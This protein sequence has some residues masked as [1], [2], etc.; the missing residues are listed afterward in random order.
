MTRLEQLKSLHADMQMTIDAIAAGE[1]PLAAAT[2]TAWAETIGNDIE[3]AEAPKFA[4]WKQC[5]MLAVLTGKT[6]GHF[7]EMQL[8]PG[9]SGEAGEAIQDL[10]LMGQAEIRGLP[11]YRVTTDK[12][13]KN[14]TMRKTLGID[15]KK[16]RAKVAA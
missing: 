12:Q 14:A 5:R 13:E 7:Q 1:Y 10:K 2:L 6:A 8:S 9:W 15:R 16:R 11:Y 3:D 4:S